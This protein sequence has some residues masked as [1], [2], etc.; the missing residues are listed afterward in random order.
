[1]GWEGL[2]GAYGEGMGLGFGGFGL[3]L[4]MCAALHPCRLPLGMRGLRALIIGRQHSSSTGR[5][6]ACV[7]GAG[8]GAVTLALPLLPAPSQLCSCCALRRTIKHLPRSRRS[9]APGRLT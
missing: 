9:C 5:G 4:I 8:V 3:S 7:C 6:G 2:R 1:M